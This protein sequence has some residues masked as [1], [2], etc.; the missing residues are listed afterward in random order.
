MAN[1]RLTLLCLS[2]QG[3]NESELMWF[4]LGQ[5]QI[6]ASVYYVRNIIKYGST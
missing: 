1:A 2:P 4:S 6:A 5:P 3:I